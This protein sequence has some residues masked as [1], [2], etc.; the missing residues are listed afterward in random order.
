MEQ[1]INCQNWT[2][3][4]FQELFTM[5]KENKGV[6]V[7]LP[8]QALRKQKQAY[9][10]CILNTLCDVCLRNRLPQQHHVDRRS[11]LASSCCIRYRAGC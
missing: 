3:Q 11:Y 2:A 5:L 1:M 10:T 6:K 7:I 9:H 4:N 8:L